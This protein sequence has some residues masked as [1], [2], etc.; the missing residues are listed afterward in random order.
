MSLF[1]VASAPDAVKLPPAEGTQY[2]AAEVPLDEQY[3]RL[4]PDD[5][6][7][8]TQQTGI[9]DPEEL[10][11]HVVQI[12]K[13]AYNVRAQIH[14]LLIAPLDPTFCLCCV[15]PSLSV[16]TR[17]Q[18][19]EVRIQVYRSLTPSLTSFCDLRTHTD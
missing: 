5:V 13:E 11:R 19:R 16:H 1:A 7:F 15:G 3:Y 2:S 18:V 10:K 6:A 12:Q 4:T 9:A 14:G 8:L 17:F